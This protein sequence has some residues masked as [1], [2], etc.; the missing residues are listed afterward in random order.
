MADVKLLIKILLPFLLIGLFNTLEYGF[1]WNRI[2]QFV[3]PAVLTIITLII[4]FV[5]RLR[6]LFFISAFFILSVMIL[7]YLLGDL[8]LANMVGSFGLALLLIVVSSYIPQLI[9]KGYLEKF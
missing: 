2:D 4:F 1:E 8:N 3:Y 5:P 9:R 6:K 7:I